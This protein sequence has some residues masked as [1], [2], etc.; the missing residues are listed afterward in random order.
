MKIIIDK[1][2]GFCFGVKRA[3]DKAFEEADKKKDRRIFTFGPLIHNDQV[4]G[5]LEELG[6]KSA[7]SI[8]EIN[9]EG[10][11]LIIRSHGIGE[12][13]YRQIEEKGFGYIDCTCPYV[14]AIH[15][16]VQEYYKKGYKIFIAGDKAHPEVIGINGWCDNSAHVIEDEKTVDKLPIYDKI[17]L[18]AQTTITKKIWDSVVDA[19]NKKYKNAIIFNTICSATEKRQESAEQL[20]KKVN[21]MIVIGSRKSSNTNKLYQICLENCDNAYHIEKAEDLPAGMLKGFETVGITAGA[22][23]PDW[24]IKEVIEKMQDNGNIM[25]D[26]VEI[27]ENQESVVDDGEEMEKQEDTTEDQGNMMEEYEKTMRPVYPGDTVKGT[28]I[29]VTDDE[30]MVNIGYKSDGIIKKEDYTWDTDVSLKD[31]IKA[32][33]ELEVMVVRINDGEGNVVLSKKLLDAEKNFNKIE[34]AFNEKTPLEGFVKEIVKGGG[35]VELMGVRAFMPASQFDVR[36]SEDLSSFVNKKVNVEIIEFDPQKR[37]VV[38]SRKSLLKKQNEIKEKA[39]WENIEVGQRLTGEI[40]RLADFGAFADIGGVDGLI[41]ISELSWSRVKHPSEIVKPGDK[42]EV[43][44]LSVDKEKKKISLGLKQTVPEPWSAA[45]EKYKPGDV[46]DVKVLRFSNFGAFVELE[47][48][49]DGLIHISQ[50]SDKRIAKPSDALKIGEI[51]KAKI[52]DIKPEEKK[53]SLSIRE[54]IEAIGEEAKEE[55]EKP[56]IE[57]AKEEAAEKPVIEEAKEEAAEKPIVEEVKEE[58]EKPAVEE[59]KE[60][61]EKS[62]IEEVKQEAAEKPIAEEAEEAAAENITEETAEETAEE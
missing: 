25:G 54:L 47:P 52:V 6:I 32:G 14:S 20:S 41:H 51:V 27:M 55:A 5:K 48:G 12:E 18:V 31:I 21:C 23:T 58:A 36:Y 56:V 62:V 49:I 7:D 22:S 15:K 35:I 10:A 4:T 3:V 53:I 17:C 24:L 38:V 9:C 44:V 16:K 34:A 30:V 59:A 50:I 61:A 2:A 33:D 46:L 13:E 37:K 26:P 19:I 8:D 40:K 28:V 43:I 60:E 39:L 57:E 29:M 45:G 42:V 1:Y 11:E